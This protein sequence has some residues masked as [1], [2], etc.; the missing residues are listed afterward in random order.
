M[1]S[2]PYVR[3]FRIYMGYFIFGYRLKYTVKPNGVLIKNNK[4][5]KCLKQYNKTQIISLRI[6]TWLLESIKTKEKNTGCP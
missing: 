1:F 2:N 3:R 5:L 4:F 6:N